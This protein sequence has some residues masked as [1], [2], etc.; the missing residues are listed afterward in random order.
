MPSHLERGV[1]YPWVVTAQKDGKEILAPTLPA[2]AEFKIIEKLALDELNRRI[3]HISSAA[4]RGALYAQVGL[5]D[6]AEQEL[7]A[8]FILHPDD[9][10]AKKLFG[11]IKSWSEP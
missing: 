11:T 4:V 9:K 10:T 7:R 2:R 3:R 8:H 5:L 1:V 6:Q